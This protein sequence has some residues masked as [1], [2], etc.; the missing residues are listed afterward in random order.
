MRILVADDH[1]AIRR[2]L[3]RVLE[4]KSDMEVVGEA[5]DGGSAVQLARQLKP[6][7]VLMDV[8][9]PR[10]NG[11]DATRQILHDRPE[12]R[13]IGISIHESKMFRNRMF[14]AGACAY[15]LKDCDTEDLFRAIESACNGGT[16]LDPSGPCS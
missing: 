15:L 14:E 9:M 7:V 3:I 1:A 4:C 2:S 12:V 11:I 6:D 13:V 10:V 16:A 8:I 5:P